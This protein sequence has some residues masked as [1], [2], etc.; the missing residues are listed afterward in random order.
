MADDTRSR[1]DRF[2]QAQDRRHAGFVEALAEIHAGRKRSHWIW[3][4]L[5]QLAGLGE[6]SMSRAYAIADRAEA[7]AYLHDP[8]LSERYLQII[9]AIA[10]Q[11]ARGGRLEDVMGSSIDTQ[12][13]ASSLTLF[14][15]VAAGLSERE[16]LP[17]YGAIART[18]RDVLTTAAGQGFPACSFTRQRLQSTSG[19]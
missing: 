8:V 1:L 13:L 15:D 5:P 6:S 16:S 7:E 4:I 12:K 10:D 14:G 19:L 17:S 2:H 18:A 9:S 3:Y 11:L